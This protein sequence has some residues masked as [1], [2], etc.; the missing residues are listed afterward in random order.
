[1][2]ST[3]TPTGTMRKLSPEE[4]SKLIG[5][6]VRSG[7]RFTDPLTKELIIIE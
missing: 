4:G 5:K 7:Q 2:P 6:P 1:M 3:A